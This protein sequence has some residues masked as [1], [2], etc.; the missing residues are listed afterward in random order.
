MWQVCG[1]NDYSTLLYKLAKDGL[2]VMVPRLFIYS[3]KAN[4]H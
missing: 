3:Q 1:K 2:C 4:S